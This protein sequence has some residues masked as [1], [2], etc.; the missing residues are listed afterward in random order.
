M[1]E[2]SIAKGILEIALS[3]AQQNGAT[4]IK[5]VRI[6]AGDLR[7]IVQEQLSRLWGFAVKDTLADGA[8][9]E[10]ERVPTKA[11]CKSCGHVFLVQNNEFI[12]SECDSTDVEVIEGME[13]DVQDIEIE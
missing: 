3:V 11:N 8:T 2:M 7:G 9:L 1:H 4:Q 13:L 5:T 6:R 12:C 10:V